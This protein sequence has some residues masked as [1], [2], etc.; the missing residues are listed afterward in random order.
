M[1]HLRIRRSGVRIS[2]GALDTSPATAGDVLVLAAK[3]PPAQARIGGVAG[4][5]LDDRRLIGLFL[6][7]PVWQNATNVGAGGVRRLAGR[8][9]HE[10]RA[11]APDRNIA[12]AMVDISLDTGH[13]VLPFIASP[14]EKTKYLR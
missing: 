10:R 8:L 13:A 11:F 9:G 2:P 14:Q 5:T 4:A 7:D 6:V 1:N 3:R 12:L